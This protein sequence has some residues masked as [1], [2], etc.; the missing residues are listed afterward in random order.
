MTGITENIRTIGCTGGGAHK[1]AKEFE[2]QLGITF[3]QFDELG[4]LVRGMNFALTNV[5]YIHI[6]MQDVSSFSLRSDKISK[7]FSY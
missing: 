7:T 1:Y 2:D 3:T 6:F 4:C 5:V